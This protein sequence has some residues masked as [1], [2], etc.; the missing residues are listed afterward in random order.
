[1]IMRFVYDGFFSVE[2]ELNIKKNILFLLP[3]ERRSYASKELPRFYDG[4][5]KIMV[6]TNKPCNGYFKQTSLFMRSDH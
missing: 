3:L 4:F 1:M 6:G 5:P 2:F